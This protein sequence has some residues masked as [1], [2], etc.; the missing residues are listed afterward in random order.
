MI[1]HLSES[2][3]YANHGWLKSYHTF[4]FADYYNPQRMHFGALRVI[5]DDFIEAGMGFGR[6]PHSNMEIVTIPLMGALAH[7]DSTGNSR[8]IQKGEVQIMSAGTGITHSE[9]NVSNTDPVTLLQIWVMPKK[10]NILPRYEQKSFNLAD[11]KNNLQLVVA[12]DGRDGALTI[13]QD[14]FFTLADLDAGKFIKY[15]QKIK[16]SGVY[17]FIISG[18]VEINDTK[19]NKRDGL[20]LTEF[21]SVNIKAKTNA[22]ILLMEVPM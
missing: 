6:H 2:R 13:N 20:A 9:F 22:E 18:E 21:A 19:L 16:A 3:G 4:S 15:E 12:P 11:R 5:N 7:D 8:I 1:L 14:A 10:M 17:L